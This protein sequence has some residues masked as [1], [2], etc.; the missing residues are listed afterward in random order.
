[1]ANADSRYASRHPIPPGEARCGG[2]ASTGARERSERPRRSRPPY[3]RTA[4][5]LGSGDALSVRADYINLVGKMK[6]RTFGS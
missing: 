2:P 4:G 1:M 5:R 3:G 6:R